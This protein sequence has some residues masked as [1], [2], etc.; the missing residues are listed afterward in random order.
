MKLGSGLPGCLAERSREIDRGR[1]P[2]F[3]GVWEGDTK[4]ANH[5]DEWGKFEGS[6]VRRPRR[7]HATAM[8]P[9][10]PTAAKSP[11]DGSGIIPFTAT[12]R[13]L[14]GTSITQFPPGPD[15]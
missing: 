8:P 4:I 6:G 15:V 14:R 3:G 11:E 7:R 9:T 12:A 5:T 2:G 1:F 13:E 10:N